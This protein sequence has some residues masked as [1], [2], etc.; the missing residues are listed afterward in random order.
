M[1]LPA[2]DPETSHRLDA[3][4]VDAARASGRMAL[5]DEAAQEARG[6]VLAS[7]NE[8]GFRPQAFGLNWAQ[9]LGPARDRVAIAT[10]L[11]DA[12]AAAILDDVLPREDLAELREPM[13]ML[14]LADRPGAANTL[15]NFGSRPTWVRVV[16]VLFLLATTT[17]SIAVALVVGPGALPLAI[18]S[19]VSLVIL[20]ALLGIRPPSL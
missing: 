1:S 18:V 20:L 8:T 17:G 7:F 2:A 3:R 10:A 6:R 19:V 4:V 13:E 16:L 11:R 12:A 5:L 14:V 15:A 9:G